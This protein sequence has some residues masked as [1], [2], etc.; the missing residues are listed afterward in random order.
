[1][2]IKRYL[3]LVTLLLIVL[4]INARAQGC[5]DIEEELLKYKKTTS[6]LLKEK[7][8][9]IGIKFFISKPFAPVYDLLKDGGISTYKEAYINHVEKIDMLLSQ[10]VESI[11]KDNLKEEIDNLTIAYHGIVTEIEFGD[12][13]EN[14]SCYDA[15][16]TFTSIFTEIGAELRVNKVNNCDG[17]FAANISKDDNGYSILVVRPKVRAPCLHIIN[18]ENN[19]KVYG[20]LICYKL[21]GNQKVARQDMTSDLVEDGEYTFRLSYTKNSSIT[22]LQTTFFDATMPSDTYPDKECN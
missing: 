19:W 3:Y 5:L 17:D 22:D 14:Q 12:F 21:N 18:K 6:S 2:N 9:G 10:E 8:I 13:D 1:M 20:I 7:G 11:N 4:S 15:L 16:Q